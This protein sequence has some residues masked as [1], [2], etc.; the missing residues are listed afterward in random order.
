MVD[1]HVASYTIFII[2]KKIIS[3]DN[4]P[5]LEYMMSLSYEAMTSLHT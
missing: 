4:F 2:K 5:L 3:A 1:V